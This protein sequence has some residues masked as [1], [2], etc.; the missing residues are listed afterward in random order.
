MKL[1]IAHSLPNRVRFRY[2]KN[3]LNSKQIVVLKNMLIIQNCIETASVNNMTGSILIYYHTVEESSIQSLILG[4]EKDYMHDQTVLDSILEEHPRQSLFAK[5][6]IMTTMHFM[7]KLLPMPIRRI[8]AIIKTIPRVELAI[9]VLYSTRRLKSEALDAASLTVAILNN[10][11]SGASNISFLLSISDTLQEYAKKISV[12]NLKD[13]LMLKNEMAQL[14]KNGEEI[15]VHVNSLF[16][17]DII[18]VRKSEVIPVDGEIVSGDAIIDQASMTGES[19]A[20]ESFKGRSVYAGTTV[21]EGEV[22]IRVKFVG[23]NTKISKIVDIISDSNLL[24]AEAQKRSE[25]LADALV[26]YNFLLAIATY[27]ITGNIR[28][29]S[30][31]IMIDYSCAMKLAAPIAVFSALRDASKQGHFVK[32][33][34]FLEHLALTD[35]IVFD[36]TGTLTKSEAEVSDITA[37]GKYSR[38]E[39]LKISACLE[40]H[41]PHSLANSIVRQAEKE[42]ISHQEEHAKVE[43]VVA[44]GISSTLYGKPVAIGSEHFILDDIKVNTDEHQKSVI[45]KRKRTGDSILYL[46]IDNNLVGIISIHDPIRKETK[47]VID[48]L[49]K[50]GVKNMS[51]ITGDGDAVAKNIA[52]ISGIDNYK[53]NAFPEDKI[54]HIKNIKTMSE[55]VVMVGD[56]INDAPAL[57]VSDVGIVMHNC[58]DIAKETSDIVLSDDGLNGLVELHVLGNKLLDRIE[59]NNNAIVIFNSGLI[60]A[61]LLGL[62]NPSVAATLHNA[63]TTLISVQSMRKFL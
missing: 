24:K 44:H 2:P 18:M 51:M 53:S 35:T 14:I 36:K 27:I 54:E 47:D 22:A 33:G 57:S 34:K 50:L 12:N 58:S 15:R 1:Y 5:L 62:I 6:L 11:Y 61:S 38:E 37:F 59:H 3:S 52:A 42:G 25:N 7:I 41:F 56:G 16:K 21:E 28:K 30:A 26:P 9:K 31:T 23:G 43:Y 48:S 45:E 10:D 4:I 49:R 40:E 63:S 19:K 29:A 20:Q 55:R 60:L 8:I 46:A 17:G 32:G 39:V 13:S